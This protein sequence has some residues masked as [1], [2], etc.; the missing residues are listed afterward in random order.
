MRFWG[1]KVSAGWGVLLLFSAALVVATQF[2]DLAGF[3]IVSVIAIILAAAFIVHAV[4]NL[5]ISLLPIP[6]AILY[7]V[8][9][10]LLGLPHIRTW[11][12]I[13]AAALSHVGLKMIFTRKRFRGLRSGGKDGDRDDSSNPSCKISFGEAKHRLTSA[14]LETVRIHCNFG[15]IKLHLDQAVPCENGAEAFVDCS[16]GAVELRVPKHWQV[17]DRIKCSVGAVDIGGGFSG[18]N[19]SKLTLSGNVTFGGIEVKAV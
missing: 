4:A 13:L 8:F 16:F 6:L 7:A 9:Q 1:T 19:A 14:A 11:P 17:V 10:D 3:G 18:E 5:N 12:L 2:G 15:F